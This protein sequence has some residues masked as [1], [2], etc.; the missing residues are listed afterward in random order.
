MWLHLLSANVL[1]LN[2]YLRDLSACRESE[3]GAVGRGSEERKH[4]TARRRHCWKRVV[5]AQY[6]TEHTSKCGANSET[7]NNS[8]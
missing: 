5:A 2:E 7:G 4:W 3:Q 1:I 6:H 8:H